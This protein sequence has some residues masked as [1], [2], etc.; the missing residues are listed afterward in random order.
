[1]KDGWAEE[2]KA[3]IESMSTEEF[4][5]IVKK[6][7]D[8]SCIPYTNDD[9]GISLEDAFGFNRETLGGSRMSLKSLQYKM[10]NKAVRLLVMKLGQYAS[11]WQE[12]YD[13]KDY[14]AGK[15]D[16]QLQEKWNFC[17]E[18]LEELLND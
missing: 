12:P 3:K 1:M 13:D 17:I 5:S 7:L 6:A 15:K 11:E 18:L 2:A 14:D 9:S 4:T 10:D 16:S 8:D